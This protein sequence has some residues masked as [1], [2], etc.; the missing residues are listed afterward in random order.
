[1]V[2]PAR[3][4]AA[5]GAERVAGGDLVA[6]AQRRALVHVEVDIGAVLDLVVDRDEVPASAGVG[7]VGGR[8]VDDHARA[9]GH[10][11]RA[12]LREDVLALVRT[13]T[14]VPEPRVALPVVE[15]A[16][17][18]EDGVGGHGGSDSGADPLTAARAAVGD[19]DP[20]PLS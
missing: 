20:A 16:A 12:L 3:A 5:D 9:H 14:R 8:L 7:A 2:A 15:V 18:R 1:M 11:L 6:F 17:D 10:Q 13:A 4:G 19:R